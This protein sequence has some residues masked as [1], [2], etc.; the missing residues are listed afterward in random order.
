[1]YSKIVGTGRYLPDKVITNFDIEKLVDTTDEWIKTRT[2]IERRHSVAEDETTS[3]MCIGAARQAIE[4]AGIDPTEMD[5]VVT[6]TAS[7]DNVFPN[8]GCYISNALGLGDVPTITLEAACS[9]FIYGVNIADLYIK[10]GEAKC[11]LVLGAESIT[12]LLDWSNRETCVLF[13]DGAGAAILKQSDEPGLLY[14]SLGADGA[15]KDLLYYPYGVGK[16]FDN[17]DPHLGTIQMDGHAVFKVA[18]STMAK[19]AKS[20][21]EHLKMNISD[22]DWLIPHQANLRII[23]AVGKRLSIPEDKVITTVQD[24]GNTSAASIPLALDVAVKDG[25]I[26]SGDL[27]LMVAFGGG[28]TWGSAVVRY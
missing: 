1:M 7:P 22:V 4:A 18:V 24:H 3:D 28:F 21:L 19:A 10:S 13:G 6:G 20:A 2:G 17:F 9:G 16:G 26:K 11:C 15:H 8:V 5:M 27:V 12:R 23:Q 25:R 14:S